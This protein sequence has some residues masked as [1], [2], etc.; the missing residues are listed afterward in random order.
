MAGL[1]LIDRPMENQA[2]KSPISRNT[3]TG[4]SSS[5]SWPSTSRVV[6]TPLHVLCA[7]LP[8]AEIII[9]FRVCLCV[10]LLDLLLMLSYRRV[11]CLGGA[12]FMSCR[13]SWPPLAFREYH[14]SHRSIPRLRLVSQRNYVLIEY[15]QQSCVRKRPPPLPPPCLPPFPFVCQPDNPTK[16]KKNLTACERRRQR[17]PNPG[18]GTRRGRTAKAG[19][20]P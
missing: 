15:L 19:P 11:I 12:L 9:V 17:R 6:W 18:G 16:K 1:P 2:R 14:R 8:F 4:T 13:T 5:R 20:S 7:G 3:E 10:C